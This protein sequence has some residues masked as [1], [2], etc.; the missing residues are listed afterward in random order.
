MTVL[1][2]SSAS[3]E[4]VAGQVRAAVEAL[5]PGLPVAQIASV[6]ALVNA[7][8][9]LALAAATIGLSLGSAALL[10]SAVGIFGMAGV[11]SRPAAR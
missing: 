9:R 5:Q 2:E 3:A 7:D 10:L 11:Y 4:A 8:R 6:D 1:V